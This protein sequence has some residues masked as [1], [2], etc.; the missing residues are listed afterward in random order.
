MPLQSLTRGG[1]AGGVRFRHYVFLFWS[2]CIFIF[3]TKNEV[4]G[5]FI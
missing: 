3:V 2:D 5:V 4:I 1:W